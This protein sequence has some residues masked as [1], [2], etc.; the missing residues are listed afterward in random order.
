MK[1]SKYY[2]NTD[3]NKPLGSETNKPIAVSAP[4]DDPEVEHERFES[5]LL[6]DA[7]LLPRNRQQTITG[8]LGSYI[9]AGTQHRWN[10]WMMARA[11]APSCSEAAVMVAILTDREDRA[12]APVSGPTFN[13]PDDCAVDRF[14]VALKAK[15]VECRAKG[16]SGWNNEALCP[17]EHLQAMLCDHVAK[18]DPV[19]VGNFAMMLF[20]RGER[21]IDSRPRSEDSLAGVLPHEMGYQ[22]ASDCIGNAYVNGWN[23]CRATMLGEIPDDPT[24][25]PVLASTTPQKADNE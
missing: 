10:G 15:M 8:E 7:P 3:R 2:D 13:H 18:G 12:A 22:Q 17:T 14:A 9:S 25:C 6:K 1:H 21:T 20:N 16:R 4:T 23:D 5:A 11:A 19:D 24:N